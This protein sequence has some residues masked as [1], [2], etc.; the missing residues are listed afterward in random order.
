MNLVFIK[1]FFRFVAII[2]VIFILL[3]TFNIPV[4]SQLR[5]KVDSMGSMIYRVIKSP[6]QLTC[7]TQKQQIQEYQTK[8]SKKCHRYLELINL[9]QVDDLLMREDSHKLMFFLETS[10]S[11]ALTI[12]QACALESAARKSGRKVF[13]LMTSD[14]LN[15][16]AEQVLVRKKNALPNI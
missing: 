15:V 13:L 10:G 2:T 12:R 3:A 8:C 9:A 14:T 16:C 7:Y 6:Y 5:D 11:S 1:I 4:F